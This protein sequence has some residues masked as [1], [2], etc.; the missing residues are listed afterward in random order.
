[1]RSN[2][3][4]CSSGCT[5][6]VQNTRHLPM[7][8]NTSSYKLS[9]W[10]P[11]EDGK[12]KP[13]VWCMDISLDDLCVT[14]WMTGSLVSYCD[15]DADWL[16]LGMLQTTCTCP[17]LLHCGMATLVHCG[18]WK[19]LLTINGGTFLLTYFLSTQGLQKC[20]AS[21]KL[22]N[23]SLMLSHHWYCS[24][25]TILYNMLMKNYNPLVSLLL[26]HTHTTKN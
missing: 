5:T 3:S 23:S 1:M 22:I 24:E 9:H 19:R 17:S 12:T 8:N 20:C 11:D 13:H 15:T 21:T 18:M 7:F 4:F 10:N 16:A 2:I 6:R 25:D 14:E 26:F